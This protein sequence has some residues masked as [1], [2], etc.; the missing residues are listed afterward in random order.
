[1]NHALDV[2]VRHAVATRQLD[3]LLQRRV[4]LRVEAIVARAFAIDAGLENGLHVLLD[5]LGAGHE[6]GDLLLLL[7]LPVDIG[8]NI[9]MVGV[10]HHHLG[11]AA[12]CAAGL[13]GAGS[14]IADLEEAHQARRLAAARK[15]LILAAQAREV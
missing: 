9:G 1:M 15:L 6:R 11:G 5:D 8:L 13:D 7:H 10:N 14:A 2:I 3:R 12:R 4:L